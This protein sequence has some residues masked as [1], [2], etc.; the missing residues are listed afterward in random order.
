VI[1][2]KLMI[3]V[4]KSVI[5]NPIISEVV[6]NTKAKLNIEKAKIDHDGGQVILS[7]EDEDVERVVSAFKKWGARVKKIKH[8]VVMDDNACISCGACISVCP[9][10]VFSFDDDGNIRV[11]EEKCIMCELCVYMCPVDA[12]NVL[13]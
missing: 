10:D 12:L 4:P 1:E 2:M 3:E 9:T 5:R 6:L 7:V 11:E 13:E 8:P